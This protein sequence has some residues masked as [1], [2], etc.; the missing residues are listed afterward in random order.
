LPHEF[1]TAGPATAR[2][3]VERREG[4]YDPG[5]PDDVEAEDAPRSESEPGPWRALVTAAPAE[6]YAEPPPTREWLLRDARQPR[7][8]GVFPLGKV[9]QLIAEGGAGKT[10]ALC[11]LAVAVATGSKWLGAFQATKGR[12]LL[13]LGE[14]DA[15]EVRRR[16]YHAARVSP[17]GAP[18]QSAIEVLPLAGAICAMLERDDRGNAVESAFLP[19]LRAY[20]QAGGFRL[21]VVDPLS[22][23]AG[24]DAEKDNAVATRFMQALESLLGP[25][26]AVLNAHHINKLSRGASGTVD[27]SSGRGSSAFFDG[28]RWQCA[29]SVERLKMDEPEEQAALGQVVTLMVTKANYAFTPDP[30]QLRRD[31]DNGGALVPLDSTDLEIVE[32]ARAGTAVRATKL[33]ERAA[34]REQARTERDRREAERRATH[35]AG[36][37]EATRRRDAEDDAAAKQIVDAHPPGTPVRRLV[38]LLQRVRACGGTR[39]H[40]ALVRVRGAS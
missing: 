32:G 21:V 3:R 15:E 10:L 16:L 8:R 22:R 27:G 40:A 9:G 2:R 26:R 29:L 28:A 7:A 20:V 25:D 17:D 36:R 37:E 24:P 30:V 14:E 23:F 38:P 5:P 6:W 34:E 18:E 13:V 35:A 33:A 31:Q 19:W 39:A 4:A 11:Q 12:V 1:P